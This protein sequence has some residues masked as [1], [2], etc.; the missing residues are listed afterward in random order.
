LQR[1][2]DRLEAVLNV[3]STSL[4]IDVGFTTPA[5]DKEQHESVNPRLSETKEHWGPIGVPN[6]DRGISASTT[7][8]EVQAPDH[9]ENFDSPRS[10]NISGH[11]T[12]SSNCATI[13]TVPPRYRSHERERRSLI[14][15]SEAFTSEEDRS[16]EESLMASQNVRTSETSL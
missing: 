3:T 16:E 9:F 6:P 13:G 8:M 12:L 2:I 5:S 15:S 4:P 7:N 14:D 10:S 11:L 1:R